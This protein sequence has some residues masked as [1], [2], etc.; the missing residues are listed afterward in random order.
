MCDN[1]C[2]LTGLLGSSP[3]RGS[4]RCVKGSACPRT[5]VESAQ[6]KAKGTCPWCLVRGRHA[7]AGDVAPWSTDVQFRASGRVLGLDSEV[8]GWG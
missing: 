3:C 8:K 4:R 6:P 7:L 1:V 5:P 2:S